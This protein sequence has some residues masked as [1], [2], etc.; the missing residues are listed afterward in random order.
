[1]GIRRQGRTLGCTSSGTSPLGNVF[2]SGFDDRVR[3]APIVQPENL[4]G[5]EPQPGV[6]EQKHPVSPEIHKR[7]VAWL[8]P[9]SDFRDVVGGS[10]GTIA[11][12]RPKVP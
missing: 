1:M 8:L 9:P 5:R 4:C 10:R 12:D 11:E 3:V 6:E 7:V 2:V